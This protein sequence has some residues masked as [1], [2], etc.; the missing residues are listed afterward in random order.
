MARLPVE[1]SLRAEVVFAGFTS[2]TY[3]LH[4]AGWQIA[5]ENEDYSGISTMVLRHEKLGVAAYARCMDYQN[6]LMRSRASTFQAQ[7]MQDHYPLTY[8]VEQMARGVLMRGVNIHTQVSGFALID[9][10]PKMLMMEEQDIYN[11]PAFAAASAPTPAE[12]L[13]VDP[14]DVSAMLDMIRKAQS[15]TQA[16]IRAR[17]R[18]REIIPTQHATIFTFPLAA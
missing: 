7:Y 3:R 14:A 13:I 8:V 2:D 4:G 12:E 10:T 15:P 11:L 5:V 18:R 6:R 17:A 9:P 16:E 1:H